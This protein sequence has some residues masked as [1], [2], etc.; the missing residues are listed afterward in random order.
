[1]SRRDPLVRLKHMLDYAR[2][3]VEMA[4]GQ[5]AKNLDQDRKLVLSLT[6]LVELIG[7]AASQVPQEVRGQ[8]PNV[9]WP[10]VVSLRNRLIHGYDVVDYGI[11]WDTV[12]EDL[13]LLITE[14][15]RIIPT[16]T[17]E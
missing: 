11:L 5:M 13:P 12:T 16:A 4:K 1:M 9:P 2:E 7:E 8:Y 17:G 14:L 3:S 10:K 6:H 15:E